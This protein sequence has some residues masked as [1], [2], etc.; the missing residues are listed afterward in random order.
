MQRSSRRFFPLL[1]LLG[2]GLVL[3]LGWLQR[4]AILDWWR[5]RNYDPP[6]RIVQL[7]DE[8]RMSEEGRHLF[9]VHHPELNDRVAFNENCTIDEESIVLGCYVAGE[10]IYLFDV[11]DPRLAGVHQVTAAHE[12][13][14]A[15]YSRLSHRERKH[16]DE[17]TASF[18][19]TLADDRIRKTIAAY[20]KRD[21]SVIANELHSI[22]AT[23][24][25]TLTPELEDYYRRYFTDR[26]AVVAYSKAYEAA[27][28]ERKDKVAAYD[29]ELDA[30]KAEIELKDAS[31]ETMSAE[32]NTERERL[33]GLLAQQ[34][35]EAYNAG[36]NSFNARVRT[37]NATVNQVRSLIDRYNRLVAERNA[38]ALEEN[39]LVKAIDSRP[40][41]ISPE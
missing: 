1:A 32:L 34:E 23:E 36:V 19:R 20:E 31:L 17:L 5:L 29:A 25:E 2:F 27:F 11:S 10:G 9:Y 22:L 15:A 41:T 3:S 40:S 8:T 18:Y 14:H 4:Y 26:T 37:Y 13:L 39:E 38:V 30:L 33:D 6:A 7:A 21:P 35:Y 24:V 12:M 16:I 28:Q